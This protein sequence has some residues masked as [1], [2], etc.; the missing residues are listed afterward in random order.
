[1]L[2]SLVL[3]VLILTIDLFVRADRLL[4]F[5][6]PPSPCIF[7]TASVPSSLSFP[8]GDDGDQ[9]TRIPAKIQISSFSKPND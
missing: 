8:A 6:S 3:L 1:M 2:V 7:L 4:P 9:N 5:L